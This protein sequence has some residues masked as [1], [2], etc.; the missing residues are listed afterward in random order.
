MMK[1]KKIVLSC[2]IILLIG[3]T[4]FATMA[5]QKKGADQATFSGEWKAKEPISLGGNI[6]CVYDEGDRMNSKTMKITEQADFLTIE[7]PDPSH[8]ASVAINE[9]LVF[10]GEEREFNLN[11]SRVW[12]KKFTVKLSP[13]RKTMT[14]KSIV[15]QM[16]A[17]PYKVNDLTQMVVNVTEVWKLS[18]DGKSITVMTNAKSNSDGEERIWKTVFEKAI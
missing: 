9:K 12:G 11:N 6:V 8:G 18:N 5:L 14:V 1:N 2:L 13:D 17:T 7:I 15:H 16:V 10:D 4:Y 3:V